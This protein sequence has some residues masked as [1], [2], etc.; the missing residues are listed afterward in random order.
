MWFNAAFS[1][2]LTLERK[3]PKCFSNFQSRP[4]LFDSPCRTSIIK[5]FLSC[6]IAHCEK[7]QPL[8]AAKNG[9]FG[10]FDVFNDKRTLRLT[11]T[12]LRPLRSGHFAPGVFDKIKLIFNNWISIFTT[13][14]IILM[15]I[16]I[17]YQRERKKSNKKPLSRLKSSWYFVDLFLSWMAYCS[18]T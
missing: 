3:V 12:S 17:L 13:A 14:S 15:F 8:K 2:G 1:H 18:Y 10:I 9:A 6:P 4:T 5:F 7:I 11:P 16:C